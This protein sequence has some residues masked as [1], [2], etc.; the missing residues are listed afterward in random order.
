MIDLHMGFCWSSCHTEEH[1]T[2]FATMSSTSK[3]TWGSKYKKSERRTCVFPFSWNGKNYTECAPYQHPKIYHKKRSILKCA[4]KVDSNGALIDSGYCQADC[5]GAGPA[6][7][8][9][10]AVGGKGKGSRCVFPFWAEKVW[11]I[12]CR[13]KN[14]AK[15]CGTDLKEDGSIEKG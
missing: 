8:A 1:A 6:K 9:V 5:P 7:K 12:E 3:S 13:S 4:T 15:Y 14:S 11:N 10:K 2:C